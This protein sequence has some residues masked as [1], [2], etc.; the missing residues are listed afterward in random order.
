VRLSAFSPFQCKHGGSNPL[1]PVLL[2]PRLPH[3]AESLRVVPGLGWRSHREATPG[4]RPRRG[5]RELDDGSRGRRPLSV[6]H[7]RCRPRVGMPVQ[8]RAEQEGELADINDEQDKSSRM[9]WYMERGINAAEPAAEDDQNPVRNPPA[10]PDAPDEPE[11]HQ[12]AHQELH[13]RVRS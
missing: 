10:T 6:I 8:G 7:V 12:P 4:G 1:S 11:C 13:P 2:V 3:G 5:A 9:L